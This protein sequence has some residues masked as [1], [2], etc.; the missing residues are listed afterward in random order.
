MKKFGRALRVLSIIV[1]PV[2]AQAQT[3]IGTFSPDPD[4]AL[5]VVAKSGQ[6]PLRL[7]GLNAGTTQEDVVVTDANGV[8]YYRPINS[9]T[10]SGE[11]RDDASSAYIYANR[12]KTEGFNQDIVVTDNGRFGIGM[13]DPTAALQIGGDRGI[14]IG[15]N[16]RISGTYDSGEAIRLTGSNGD[17]IM[18]VQDGTGRFTTKWNATFGS[19]ER[20]LESGDLAV[21]QLING[22]P[23]VGSDVY[24]I[25][26]ST[27]AGTAG[28]NITWEHLLTIENTG[29]VGIGTAGPTSKLDVNGRVRVRDLPLG[30]IAGDPINDDRIVTADDQGNLREVP[31]ASLFSDVGEWTNSGNNQYI[32]AR[33]AKDDAPSHNVVVTTNGEIGLGLV[34]PS[35]KMHIRDGG[36]RFDGEVN[37]V[38]YGLGFN[39]E[40]TTAGVGTGDRARIYFDRH[41]LGSNDDALIIEKTDGNN[42]IADGAILFSSRGTGATRVDNM[43]IEGTGD[44]GIGLSNP[45]ERLHVFGDVLVQQGGL[46]NSATGG[47]I[48]TGTSTVNNLPTY[49]TNGLVNAVTGDFAYFGQHRLS[50][51][52]AD[53]VIVWGDDDSDDFRFV[54]RRSSTDRSVMHL[55]GQTLNVGIGTTGV[56][57][58]RLH[59]EG[60]ARVTNL[61]SGDLDNNGTD[62][63]VVT[64][65]AAGNLR[66]VPA[67]AIFQDFQD[68]DWTISGN[69]IYNSNS[70]NVGIGLNNPQYKLDIHGPTRVGELQPLQFG[71]RSE[72]A[73]ATNSLQ[74]ILFRNRN[75]L[76]FQNRQGTQDLMTVD[77]QSGTVG[78]GTITPHNSFG[79]D[80]ATHMRVRQNQELHFGDNTRGAGSNYIY[81]ASDDIFRVRAY[82]LYSIRNRGDNTDI[83]SVRADDQ[84]VGIRTDAPSTDFDVNGQV[85]VRNLPNGATGDLLV[86]TDASGNLRQIPQATFEGPWT[87]DNGNGGRTFLRNVTDKVGVGL[88]S[89]DATFHLYEATGTDA[90]A[91]AHRARRG[92]LTLEHGN[93]GGSSSIVFKSRQN[94]N[95]DFGYINYS[96][97]GSGNGTSTENS[98]LEIG[99]ENDGVGQY[100]DDIAIMPSGRLGVKTR[101]PSADF[102]LNGTARI[103]NLPTNTTDP[104]AV[105]TDANG[106][107]NKQAIS[108][109]K[110]NL[111][112]H[113]MTQDL[114]TNGEA[115]SYNGTNAGLKMTPQ[116]SAMF[117]NRLQIGNIVGNWIDD[118][119]SGITNTGFAGNDGAVFAPVYT[120]SENSDLRLYILDNP[121]D[122]FSIWGNPCGTADCGAINASSQV[123]RFRADGEITFNGLATGGGPNQMVLADN[124]GRLILGGAPGSVTSGGGDN[125]G[126]HVATRDIILGP[127]QLRGQNGFRFDGGA[128]Q[129]NF[130]NGGAMFWGSIYGTAISGDVDANTDGNSRDLRFESDDDM[131]F[132]SDDD[133]YFKSDGDVVYAIDDAYRFSSGTGNN[134]DYRFY[135]NSGSNNPNNTRLGNNG[136]EALRIQNDTRIRIPNLGGGGNRV[137]MADNNGILY[138]TSTSSDGLWE[139]DPGNAETYLSNT[140][141]QV[142]I[143][144]ADPVS[145]L[146]LMHDGGSTGL[147]NP[148]EFT[149]TNSRGN[150]GTSIFF[151][152]GN[153]IS[154]GF[155]LVYDGQDNRFHIQEGDG[156]QFMSFE[157]GT[158]NVGIGVV[159]PANDARLHVYEETTVAGI[160]D[161]ARVRIQNGT[162]EGSA[163]IELMEGAGG[164]DRNNGMSLRYNS[165]SDGSANGFE[166]V[167]GDAS[168]ANATDVMMRIERNTGAT[169]FS[170][171]QGGGL[172]EVVVADINGTISKRPIDPLLWT[173][174]GTTLYQATPVAATNV[175]IGTTSATAKL[176]VAGTMRV[177]TLNPG[178]ATDNFVVADANGNFR[179]LPASTFANYF[180]R[181]AT[182]EVYLA[183]SA[184]RLGVGVVPAAGTRLHVGAGEVILDQ[185][186][187]SGSRLVVANAAGQLSTASL[188][189]YESHWNRNATTS[190]V[191]LANNGDEVG[192]GTLSPAAKFHVNGTVRFDNLANITDGEVVMA[193]ANGELYT[194]AMPENYWDR[195]AA[196]SYTILA[197]GGDNVGIGTATPDEALHIAT[198]T[199]KIDNLSAGLDTDDILVV[200]AN[201]VV[202][203]VDAST[204]TSPWER[205][206]A[207]GEIFQRNLN[208]FVGI[209]I[210]TPIS[211]LHISRVGGSDLNN[212][213]ELRIQ[214]RTNRGTAQIRFRDNASTGANADNYNSMLLR[215]NGTSDA[216]E[217]ANGSD[218][219]FFRMRRRNGYIALSDKSPMLVP[220]ERLHIDGN[221]RFENGSR[222]Q[223]NENGSRIF[224]GA[225]A[226]SDDDLFVA[227]QD[228]LSLRGGSNSEGLRINNN[229]TLYAPQ[230]PGGTISH[231]IVVSANGNLR[232]VSPIDYK[233]LFDGPWNETANEVTLDNNSFNVGIGTSPA[234]GIKFHVNGAT[235]FNT[236]AGTGT[237]MVVADNVG[238]IS[239][240]AIPTFT[241]H[242]SRV[243]TGVEL[244]N[245][246][247]NVGIGTPAIAGARLIVAG[248][249]R[250]TDLATG[251]V[252]MVVA[253][254][255]GTLS[256]QPIPSFTNYWA[257][258]GN[259]V[260]LATAGDE[261]G[262][263]VS[264]PTATLHVSGTLRFEGLTTGN[265]TNEFLVV[266][267]TGQVAKLPASAILSPWSEVTAGKV[268][269]PSAAYQVGIGVPST[270]VSE[271]LTM[272]GNQ[273]L[274]NNSQ[275]RFGDAAAN[276][277]REAMGAAGDQI[278][279]NNTAGAVALVSNRVK[280]VNN[281]GIGYATFD[282]V[283]RRLALGA[284]TT[285]NATLHIRSANPSTTP[286]LM[287]EQMN[288]AVP[289]TYNRLMIAPSGVVVKSLSSVNENGFSAS[290]ARL[291][292]VVAPISNVLATLDEL[293]AI[294]FK[295][296]DAATT[297]LELDSMTHYGVIA[298]EIQRHWPHAVQ[299][300]NGY[301]HVNYM[302]LTGILLAASKELKAENELL[303]QRADQ[304]D[305]QVHH[306][307]MDKAALERT[308]NSLEVQTAELQSNMTDV[309]RHLASQR[310]VQAGD[311]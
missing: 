72:N 186:A 132:D 181:D 2:L 228:R 69:N 70:G 142:G 95:S 178:V 78:I 121:N 13:V 287:I 194:Q 87:R 158:S 188:G 113:Q 295:Y 68:D 269:L 210:N 10:L 137:V 260:S 193:D 197:N 55:D 19:N 22:D 77:G 37:G 90:L 65:D 8:L 290:D 74:H 38:G 101:N 231:E 184:D 128:G 125:L 215:Y 255:A 267:T 160:G 92:S 271:A 309:L 223:F 76:R 227:A 244:A 6:Q 289:G 124:Q 21:K 127:H 219:T 82:T 202:K 152:E 170:T 143:G 27:T 285:A 166:I 256:K 144:T 99:I 17:V 208:D 283:N 250:L 249:T 133:I 119:I 216:M 291:K 41:A 116:N 61:P 304:L 175:G 66:K 217:M 204:F 36:M 9:L 86:S 171:L 104:F 15:D 209:G 200:D 148:V 150:G 56:P 190:E 94:N 162:A 58:A 52:R 35:E 108:S 46:N 176:D 130:P 288:S 292:D 153:S 29:E 213:V 218:S 253:D 272:N 266:N 103:E 97:D 294:T 138:P 109:I 156:T 135:V 1:W 107:L 75:L 81:A 268:T 32:Y 26:K 311:R 149:L 199:I 71:D 257:R 195:D 245:A 54:H 298:Q 251:G 59:V 276:I 93:N 239:T 4:K 57:S 126:N 140:N 232:T 131:W 183:N 129:I 264:A 265:T 236:L 20:F 201:G 234:T 83:L 189:A 51:N 173:S 297:G 88:N 25:S 280:L 214:N 43:V 270:Q 192:I 120:G 23:S 42:A 102:H 281:S 206:N 279:I 28:A 179:A 252:Q 229:G 7:Q 64:A 105:T 307:M 248:P 147:V 174:N 180:S 164:M 296:K 284:V 293:Q 211:P 115:I 226:G 84:R 161:P 139:R 241:N 85:R 34:N 154:A 96:D 60:T 238:V 235:R 191:T 3:G 220:T 237:R 212:P 299:E 141:D 262:I 196:N 106:N 221:I 168:N 247:D 263:G 79:F 47:V 233:P 40:T 308:V 50:N 259:D 110:D 225:N 300:S 305:E 33:R 185:L 44:I 31:A 53:G 302:E 286:A 134:D 282:G 49:A 240:Q 182:G 146:H 111:G 301:L 11:W 63:E 303:S 80:V 30:S 230:L 117:S 62:D 310:E 261:V 98:L 16:N 155:R 172:E 73:I 159:D 122:A 39:G 48:R 198:G 258:S 118:A 277:R 145:A 114:A 222:I 274:L 273:L 169:R 242:W 278:S 14:V 207:D 67:S 275:V 163:A 203:S 45:T 18:A 89:P 24:A 224:D 187:G 246:G 112:N 136:N 254:N 306:M 157:R 5:H 205:D 177:R 243:G 12:A 123:A 100:Q 151:Q 167:R 91:G 165:S